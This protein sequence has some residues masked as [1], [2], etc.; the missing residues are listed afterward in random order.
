[1]KDEEEKIVASFDEARLERMLARWLKRPHFASRELVLRSAVKNFMNND[2]VAVIKIVLTEIEGV[3]NTAY[4]ASHGEGA[5]VETL[6]RFAVEAATRKAGH[7]YTLLLP[8]AFARYLK[9]RTFARFDPRQGVGDASSR[10]AV[11][12]GA[13]TDASYTQVSALQA[14][15]TLDQIAFAT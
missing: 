9:D 6:M 15:L 4:R 7:P 12:H 3:L 14:L 13:A 5:K 11:G 8:E 1:L 10:H 2:P